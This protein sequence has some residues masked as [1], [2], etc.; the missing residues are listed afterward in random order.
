M[1]KTTSKLYRVTK[2]ESTSAALWKDIETGDLVRFEV[3]IQRIGR[4]S[5]G[6]YAPTVTIIDVKRDV[7]HLT[8]FNMLYRTVGYSIKLEE[9]YG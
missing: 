1:I 9:I 7:K 2:L 5:R 8:T 3:N 4:A 6:S